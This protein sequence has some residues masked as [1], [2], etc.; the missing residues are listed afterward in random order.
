MVAK[1]ATVKARGF[2]V[3]EGRTLPRRIRRTGIDVIEGIFQFE[4]ALG[5]GFGVVLHLRPAVRAN[6]IA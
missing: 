4:T 5:R 1:R 3:A 2:A 6:V